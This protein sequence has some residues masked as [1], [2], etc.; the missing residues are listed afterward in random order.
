MLSRLLAYVHQMARRRHLDAEIDDELAFHL[1]QEIQQQ[2]ARGL[3]PAEARRV[4][5]RDL[6]GLTQTREATRAVRTTWLDEIGRDVRYAT[7]TLRQSPAFTTTAVTTLAL[8]LGANTVMFSVLN[9]VVLRPLPYRSPEQ[10]AMLFTGIPTA[11]PQGRAA[12]Q[13]VEEWRRRNRTFTD[14]AVL[15]PVSVTMT[16]A[17]GAEKVSVARVSPNFFPMLGVRPLH[18]H[19][20]SNEEADERRRVAL[21]SHRFWQ[22]RFGGAPVAIG[23]SIVLDGRPSEIIGILPEGFDVPRLNADVWEPHTV[24]PDWESR[25][26]GRGVGS[27]TVVGRLRPNVTADQAQAEM[28]AIAH[29]L[30]NEWPTADRIQGTSVIPLTLYV[31]GSTSRLAL[32]ILT[33][34]VLCVL[35]IAAAN[36]T[37]LSIARGV[38]RGREMAIRS[39]LGASVGRLVRQLLIESVTLAAISGVLGTALAWAGIRLVRAFGPLDLARLNEVSL[40][41]RVLG[42]AVVISLLAGVLVGAASATTIRGS[43]LRL[44]GQEGGRSVAGGLATRKIRRALVVTE[45]ALAIMLMAGAGLLVRSWARVSN[46]DPGFRPE[47][48][49]FL[50]LQAPVVVAPAQRARFY[51]D[52]IE[53]VGT[54]PGVESAG[55]IGD[56]FISNDDEHIVTTEENAGTAPEPMRLRVDE[57]SERIFTTLG[58]PLL[59]GR[60]FSAEDGADAPHVAIV[61][62]T[63]A[64]RVWAG[65]DPVGR[66]LKVGPGSPWFRV[67]GVVGDMRREG[68]ETEPIAQ[69][70]EPLVQYPSSRE[71]LLV[72]TTANDPLKMAGAVQAAARRVEKQTPLYDV[73][74]L[75][76]ALA[77][78]LMQR[79]FQ[80]SLLIGMSLVA[81]LMAAIGIYGLIHYSVATRTQEI[82]IRMA[83]GA[84][85]GDILRMI[86]R[87][88]LQLSVA[89]LVLGLVGA[90][91]VGQ[92][93]TSL[94]FGVAATDPLT[95]MTASLLLTTV[96]VAACYFP[97]RRATTVDPIVALRVT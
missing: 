59:R 82:S 86:I 55:I 28:S 91:L 5:L 89:G 40:D 13:T 63:M 75:E 61:N 56:L 92:V 4:A 30:D 36:V 14:L 96:A 10:L 20:F 76:D 38:S 11:N 65:R 84:Q 74:T 1:E 53:Q 22:T 80:T 34:A 31:V 37:S 12:Y 25:R 21:I 77:A 29:A 8:A 45:C 62:E 79:R 48:V 78:S 39:A 42:A 33:G 43:R 26:G 83:I 6:G 17:D 94:L 97:A 70:F 90:L 71:I 57:A 47:G 44:S 68:L 58:T 19:S 93:S 73:T 35:L 2:V 67:V 54:V 69:M 41:L 72:R 32:W 3:S 64:R 50:K 52:V 9:A 95:F 46:V 60:F 18:G 7:R 27:W 23:S 49:L 24:F 16:D 85:R 15:D 81:L 66:R 88:G 51:A 87:E